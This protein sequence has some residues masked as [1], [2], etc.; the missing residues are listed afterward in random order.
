MD[1]KKNDS[2][3][4]LTVSTTS[5][6]QLSTES[7]NTLNIGNDVFQ[8]RIN[9][10]LNQYNNLQSDCKRS[11]RKSK[12]KSKRR[13]KRKSNMDG[14]QGSGPNQR[15]NVDEQNDFINLFERNANGTYDCKLF[16]EFQYKI[17]DDEDNESDSQEFFNVNISLQR[18]RSPSIGVKF[19]FNIDPDKNTHINIGRNWISS[20]IS[21]IIKYIQ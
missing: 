17:I 3:K 21:N 8:E 2:K 14:V 12:R 4:K 19:Y 10:I 6:P 20:E 18:I 1:E 5:N 15:L 11:K 7:F 13:S 16:K 9:N